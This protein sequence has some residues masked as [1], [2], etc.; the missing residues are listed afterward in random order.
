MSSAKIIII[1]DNGE[2]GVELA[3]ACQHLAPEWDILWFRVIKPEPDPLDE[4]IAGITYRV[5]DSLDEVAKALSDESGD[6]SCD[7]ILFYDLQ[8]IGVQENMK[9]VWDSPLTSTL[10]SLLGQ[11]DRR[12][13][14]NIHSADLAS[15]N[16]AQ[17]L[18]E[19]MRRVISD[20][21]TGKEKHYIRK[22][23][24]KT[25]AQWQTLYRSEFISAEEFLRVME[26]MTHA[27]IQDYPKFFKERLAGVEGENIEGN[28]LLQKYPA[29]KDV[30]RGYLGM[31]IHEFEDNFCDESK[32]LKAGVIEA[33]KSISGIFD[34][35]TNVYEF[36][37]LWWSGAWLLALG[38]FRR[39]ACKDKW[40]EVFTVEDLEGAQ[41]WPR[42]HAKQTPERRRKTLKLFGEMCR[43]M[44]LEKGTKDGC[45]LE[46]VT[47]TASKG[48]AQKLSFLLSFPCVNN[49]ESQKESLLD[50][51]KSEVDYALDMLEKT[52]EDIKVNQGHDTSRAI[53]RFFLSSC[54][55]DYKDNVGLQ[56]DGIF[57][58]LTRVNIVSVNGGKKTE[59]VWRT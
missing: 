51:I 3:L 10:K 34:L 50:R 18:D 2:N 59:V 44:F 37:R 33:L 8:L 53:W 54:I 4:G 56:S 5:I 52:K 58:G 16:V 11:A 35:E 45:V 17:A 48:E 40:R 29:P 25:L 21:V 30:L 22:V 20:V 36:R 57:G 15:L 14:L 49:G 42:V 43:V 32:S 41:R 12:V 46:K 1:D 38:E 28:V 26:G 27:Q 9:T 24:E 55:C 6:A 47:L 13:L 39:L 23:V 19:K 31:S 7:L